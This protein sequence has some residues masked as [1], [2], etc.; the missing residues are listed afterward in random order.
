MIKTVESSRVQHHHLCIERPK[1]HGKG[2]AFTSLSLKN[3]CILLDKKGGSGYLRLDNVV[4]RRL[5]DPYPA[6]I[7]GDRFRDQ[8]LSYV[9]T[10]V[11]ICT[12]IVLLMIFK[13]MLTEPGIYKYE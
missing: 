7:H 12:I 4:V 1:T 13:Y 3:S 10:H 9:A 2:K 8:K 6:L 11:A 5:R